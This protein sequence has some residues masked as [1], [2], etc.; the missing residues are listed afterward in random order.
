[1]SIPRI[2]SHIPPEHQQEVMLNSILN[3]EAHILTMAGYLMSL[4]DSLNKEK[5]PGQVSVDFYHRAFYD[6]A[7]HLK[8]SY[9]SFG[10]IET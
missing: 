5:I 6:N 1:M 10:D 7:E 9:A 2:K 4:R 3:I 8:K